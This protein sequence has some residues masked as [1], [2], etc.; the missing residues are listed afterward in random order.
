MLVVGK[1]YPICTLAGILERSR[2]SSLA[3]HYTSNV[4]DYR[5]TKRW[6]KETQDLS[7]VTCLPQRRWSDQPYHRTSEAQYNSDYAIFGGS[8]K[9]S[10]IF[11][12]ITLFKFGLFR[13]GFWCLYLLVASACYNCSIRH[14]QKPKQSK[15]TQAE[16]STT[17]TALC[18]SILEAAP[19]FF[20]YYCYEISLVFR[21]PAML[22]SSYIHCFFPFAFV[23]SIGYWWILKIFL[24]C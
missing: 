19:S 2:G 12:R 9:R 1:V 18:L 3:K 11:L 15:K 4:E 21:H 22:S 10:I 16:P 20:S 7:T 6:F 13:V 5:M 14:S 8:K 17:T 23:L 24:V